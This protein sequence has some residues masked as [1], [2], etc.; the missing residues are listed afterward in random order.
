[1]KHKSKERGKVDEFLSCSL[2]IRFL[3]QF[4]YNK[5]FRLFVR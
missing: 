1:M 5:K 2:I 4:L 3:F